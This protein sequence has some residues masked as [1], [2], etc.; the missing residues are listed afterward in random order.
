MVVTRIVVKYKRKHQ[1]IVDMLF[2]F[3][4]KLFKPVDACCQ[5]MLINA[6]K[7]NLNYNK[8]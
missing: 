8:K 2:A 1:T 6:T 7:A 5:I 3:G 4:L